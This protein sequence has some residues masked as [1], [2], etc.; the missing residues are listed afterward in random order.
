MHHPE[1]LHIFQLLVTH[2]RL[3]KQIDGT[4]LA[5]TYI[6]LLPPVEV[7]PKK[8]LPKRLSPLHTSPLN[9]QA[10]RIAFLAGRQ[11]LEC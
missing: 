11:G 7:P 2:P 3:R 1:F 8:D 9:G 4:G 6:P 5:R 10:Y